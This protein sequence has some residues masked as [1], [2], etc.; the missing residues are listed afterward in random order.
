[1]KRVWVGVVAAAA[2]VEVVIEMMQVLLRMLV[3]REEEIP[4]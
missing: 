1:M 4:W 3:L 2:R